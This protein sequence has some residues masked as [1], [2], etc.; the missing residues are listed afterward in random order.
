[1]K[2]TRRFRLIEALLNKHHPARQAEAADA[3][4][5]AAAKLA[6][7]LP[8]AEARQLLRARMEKAIDDWATAYGYQNLADDHDLPVTDLLKIVDGEVEPLRAEL[9]QARLDRDAAL[10]ELDALKRW[11]DNKTEAAEHWRTR[12]NEIAD[13]RDQLTAALESMRALAERWQAAMR[14]GDRHPAAHALLTALDGPR[15][16]DQTHRPVGVVAAAEFGEPPRCSCGNTVWPHDANGR[17]VPITT[18]DTSTSPRTEGTN[19]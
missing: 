1:M 12:M 5:A 3:I 4:T 18:T 19:R 16:P 11:C 8:P 2:P 15:Q 17:H 10:T 9:E 14:P 7:Q 6:D 13:E